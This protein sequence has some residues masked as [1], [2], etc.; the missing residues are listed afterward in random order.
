[1]EHFLATVRETIN[2]ATKAV[3]VNLVR[4]SALLEGLK[5]KVRD[6]Y[7]MPVHIPAECELPPDYIGSDQD[8]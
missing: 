1:M 7:S 6:K 4:D 3:G 2:P 5:I 8:R